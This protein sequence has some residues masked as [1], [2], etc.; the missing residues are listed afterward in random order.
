MKD[1]RA[2]PASREPHIRVIA[3][4]GSADGFKSLTAI[5]E[6]LPR[7]FP[8]AVVITQH[9]RR[10]RVSVLARLLARHC[11]LPVKEAAKDEPLR[12]STSRGPPST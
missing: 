7:D 10:G 2:R 12:P 4:G 1:T 5:L 8:A 3:I 6:A 11:Q 9:R